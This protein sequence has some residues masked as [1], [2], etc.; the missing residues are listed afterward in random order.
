LM[1]SIAGFVGLSIA[2]LFY[3]S[4]IH[5]IGVSRATPITS[6]RPL[7]TAVLAVVLLREV[8]TLSLGLGTM[9]IVVGVALVTLRNQGYK[10]NLGVGELFAI[11]TAFCWGLYPVLLKVGL[12]GLQSVF[13]ASLIM[14]SMATVLYVLLIICMGRLRLL[15][16]IK[17]RSLFFFTL[18][19]VANSSANLL[20]FAALMLVPVTIVTPLTNLYPFFALVLSAITL[21]EKA[22]LKVFFGTVLIFAGILF[23]TL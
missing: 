9:F 3:F 8:M 22:T 17:K 10:I 12:Q 13:K 2:Y 4:S 21:N 19:G 1:L 18:S 15:F 6:S 7:I 23:I 5:H 11:L 14:M 20:Y 16:F